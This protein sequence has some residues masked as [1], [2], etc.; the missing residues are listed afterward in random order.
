MQDRDA[1]ECAGQVAQ[2]AALLD[3]P[4]LVWWRAFPAIDLLCYRGRQ[5]SLHG[6]HSC[7]LRRIGQP[8]VHY[9]H[10]CQIRQG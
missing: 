8:C 2:Q 3:K 10:A 6:G 7:A 4:N 5:H 9:P 1:K